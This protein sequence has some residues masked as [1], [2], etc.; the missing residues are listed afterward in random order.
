M[1]QIPSKWLM[2]T[3]LIALS[4]VPPQTAWKEKSLGQA[5]TGLWI[6]IEMQMTRCSINSIFRCFMLYF[7]CATI[8]LTHSVSV[9]LSFPDIDTMQRRWFLF[10]MSP[11]R[12][13]LP[14]LI[15]LVVI[16]FRCLFVRGLRNIIG[17][18]SAESV[19]CLHSAW[20]PPPDS[21]PPDERKHWLSHR[22][23]MRLWKGL[24]AHR[25]NRASGLPIPHSDTLFQKHR[26]QTPKLLST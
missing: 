14:P 18:K 22:R 21:T 7:I 8:S 26:G 12:W 19:L 4:D 6:P 13:D 11:P 10:I 3:S 24:S 16:W 5:V 17:R 20:R 15:L 1:T 25:N 2:D 23:S 9:S